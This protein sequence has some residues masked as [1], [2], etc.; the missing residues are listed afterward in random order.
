M[1]MISYNSNASACMHAC[2]QT[3]TAHSIHLCIYLFVCSF[4]PSFPPPFSFSLILRQQTARGRRGDRNHDERHKGTG[5]F[6]KNTVVAGGRTQLF[7]FGQSVHSVLLRTAPRRVLRCHVQLKHKG[8]AV[9]ANLGNSSG[10][11]EDRLGHRERFNAS[12]RNQAEAEKDC[13]GSHYC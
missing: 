2:Q 10:V 9:A 11:P 3:P 13:V 5:C 7:H 12:G 4:L 6:Y 8:V 1:S